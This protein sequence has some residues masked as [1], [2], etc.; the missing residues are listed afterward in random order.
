VFITNVLMSRK[1]GQMA[2]DDPWEA[3]SLEWATASPPPNYNFEHLP[4]ASGRYPLWVCPSERAIVTGL[5]N[6]RREVLVT[7]LMDADPR[8][9]YVLPGPS[10]W[11]LLA[12]IAVTVGFAGSVFNPWYVVPGSILTGLALIGWFWPHR[13]VEIQP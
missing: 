1:H 7:T 13:P 4:V 10:I 8:Y 11:P 5:R 9:R 2:G 6:D 12:A 3:D